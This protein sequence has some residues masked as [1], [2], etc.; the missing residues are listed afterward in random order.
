[1]NTQRTS[2]FTPVAIAAIIATTG[3]LIAGP[4]NPPA[5]PIAST[6]KTTQEI[7]DKVGVSE[8]RIAINNT[9][10]PGDANSLFR[11]TQ[12]GSYYLTGNITGV[13][14]KH[15]IEIAASN[16]SIDLSGFTVMGA[17]SSLNGIQNDGLQT[18]I[19]ISNGSVDG[20]GLS[21]ISLRFGAS[22]G[23]GM[24]ISDVSVSGN[25]I[26]GISVPSLSV[27]T[28]CQALNTLLTTGAGIET[29]S[30][31]IVTQCAV[32]FNNG[33][34]IFVGTGSAVSHCI[35]A[36]NATSGI[37]A[38]TGST[39]TNCSTRGNT[40]RG[41]TALDGGVVINCSAT[42]NGTDGIYAPQGDCVIQ[43]CVAESNGDNGINVIGGSTISD[44]S[45]NTNGLEGIWAGTGCMILNN[46]CTAN[47]Q[48]PAGGAGI[49]VVGS[50]NRIEGNN[51]TFA[52]YG[53]YV[54]NAQNIILRN[55]CHTN[56]T[57]WQVIAGNKCLVVQGMISGTISGNAG[58]VSIGSTDP[59]ANFTY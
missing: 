34:G 27:V 3:L 14:S 2:R 12:P 26:D 47:G 58:G 45:S 56:T 18:S 43:S 24:R 54:E 51:C 44:C 4:L 40:G 16:V 38:M 7:F 19:R 11:I 39:I 1:M 23:E 41:I 32:H 31:S 35:A 25:H 22:G 6:G 17:A 59:H 49:R 29:G 10:T 50:R 21:G 55:T 52:D 48:D 36:T 28:N 8:P 30:D 15:G 9:N 46:N 13:A 20:W 42:L 33:Y 5:G 37:Y 53:I 57:N